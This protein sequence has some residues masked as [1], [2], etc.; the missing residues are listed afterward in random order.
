MFWDY[1]TLPNIGNLNS[2]IQISTLG[3]TIGY[4]RKP[5]HTPYKFALY[6]LILYCIGSLLVLVLVL[7]G[8]CI[9]IVLAWYHSILYAVYS[10]CIYCFS[11]PAQLTLCHTRVPTLYQV[12]RNGSVQVM[13]LTVV[14]HVRALLFPMSGELVAAMGFEN[15]GHWFRHATSQSNPRKFEMLQI[16]NHNLLA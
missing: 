11:R 2:D 15:A 8:I 14:P 5:S 3:T 12:P 13:V 16:S 4:V 10:S 9:S 1:L 6:I 7:V